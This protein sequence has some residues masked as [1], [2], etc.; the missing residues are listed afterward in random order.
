MK[1]IEK[2]NTFTV[3]N[4]NLKSITIDP[5]RFK[6]Y[7]AAI[8][9][10]IHA[11]LRISSVS[12]ART[13]T[14]KLVRRPKSQCADDEIGLNIVDLQCDL[15]MIDQVKS[16]QSMFGKGEGNT[17]NYIACCCHKKKDYCPAHFLWNYIQSLPK[18]KAGTSVFRNL[19]G[20]EEYGQVG[21][22]ID[23]LS[24]EIPLIT[25]WMLSTV[26][27]EVSDDRCTSHFC[28]RTSC[29]IAEADPDASLFREEIN[30]HFQWMGDGKN[31]MSSIYNGNSRTTDLFVSK[32]INKCVLECVSELDMDVVSSFDD[33]EGDDSISISAS[34]GLDNE[35]TILEASQL[36]DDWNEL[37]LSVIDNLEDS[38]HAIVIPPVVAPVVIPQVIPPVRGLKRK[39]TD[40]TNPKKLP[41]ISPVAPPPTQVK[42]PPIIPVG[43]IM[44]KIHK[45]VLKR[46]D[47]PIVQ[48]A[49]E[50][51]GHR[52]APLSTEE[53]MVFHQTMQ[54]YAGFMSSRINK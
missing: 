31:K 45:P 18:G 30:R 43:V 17:K 1:L 19:I 50:R 20:A 4:G 37:D 7:V 25:P 9:L 16:K 35:S 40:D 12:T 22:T 15:M 6:R 39:E 24:R 54:M 51:I 5:N 34:I 13:E 36:D 41:R 33:L 10:S 27:G 53:I 23:V 11:G 29:T 42:L 2:K 52:S 32:T 49:T 38:S 48:K 46:Q 21:I 47:P 28:K 3:L 44:E 26:E 8:L 14:F